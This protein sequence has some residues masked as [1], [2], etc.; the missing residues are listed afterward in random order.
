MSRK[1]EC[2]QSSHQQVPL[3]MDTRCFQS[4]DQYTNYVTYFQNRPLRKEVEV[5]LADFAGH[6]VLRMF[7]DQGWTSM[8]VQFGLVNLSVVKEFYANLEHSRSSVFE[9]TTWVRGKRIV[10]TPDSWSTFLE[11]G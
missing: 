2:G 6:P 4:V 11:I 8:L 9:F 5:V 1:R 10:I 3:D 7:E